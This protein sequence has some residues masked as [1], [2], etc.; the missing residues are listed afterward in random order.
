MAKDSHALLLFL[1]WNDGGERMSEQEITAKYDGKC[2]NCGCRLREGER[3][4]YDKDAPAKQKVSCLKCGDNP[5]GDESSNIPGK[6]DSFQQSGSNSK[7]SLA[8]LKGKTDEEIIEFILKNQ[9]SVKDY[10]ESHNMTDNGYDTGQMTNLLI[11]IKAV[12]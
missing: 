10:F 7:G 6:E 5:N 4:M 9:K 11:L 12:I 2:K 1:L 3:I 8:G